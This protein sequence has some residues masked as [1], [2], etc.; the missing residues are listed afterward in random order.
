MIA[1]GADLLLLETIFDTL[2]AKAAIYAFEDIFAETG[3][4]LPVM[5]SGTITDLS[6][7]TLSGQTPAAFW[8]SVRQAKPL[9]ISGFAR[10]TRTELDRAA[11]EVS[12]N[13]GAIKVLVAEDSVPNRMLIQSGP[14]GMK[15]RSDSPTRR[16]HRRCPLSIPGRIC[17]TNGN[18]ACACRWAW[19]KPWTK[20]NV[21]IG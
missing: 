4:R 15:K 9:T 14:V 17:V 21:S 19:K 3:V 20:S 11:A 18:T 6:G 7:R 5:I 10:Q 16:I 1:G 8:H 12:R 13:R 2:N